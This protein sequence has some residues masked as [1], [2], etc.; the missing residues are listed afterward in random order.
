M[1]IRILPTQ[2]INQIAAGEVVER[3]A[4]AVKELV[5][6]SFDAGAR[7]VE[8][9]VEQGGLRLL[10]IRDD[11]CGIAR[12]ELSLALSRH[13]T[14]KI[15]GLDDLERVATMGFRGEAL[16]SISSVSRLTLTS[17][18]QGEDHAWRVTADGTETDFDI[19]PAAHPQGTS[20]EV[21]DLFYNTP[22][23]RK[24]LR[25]EKTEF[26]H[27]DNLVRRMALSRFGIGFALT[28]NQRQVLNLRP[29][30]SRADVEKRLSLVLGEDFLEQALPVEFG[31]AGL[32]LSGWVG[33]PT[34]SR[35]QT[36]M[37][38]FYVN[39][40][41]VRDKLV[42][43]AIRQAYQDVL[44][45]GR[46]P[47]YVLYLEL[48]PAQV[49][50]NAHPAKLEVRFR[51]SRMVHDFLFRG[52][53]RALAGTKAGASIDN[54]TPLDAFSPGQE[55]SAEGFAP[56]RLQA[57][58]SEPTAIPAPRPPLRMSPQPYAGARPAS[59]QESLPLNVADVMEGY[60]RLYAVPDASPPPQAVPQA[61]EETVPPLGFALAHLHGAFILAENHGGLIL[62]DAHAAHE[63]ITYEKLKTQC[64]SGS[65]ASQP[66]LLPIRLGV[67][68]T[69]ADLAEEAAEALAA[70]GVEFSR[71]GPETLL[72][73]AVPAL[74][75][76]SDGERLARDLLA[77]LQQHGRS[78]RVEEAM[79]SV[80]ATLACHGSV[81][82]NRRL[83]VPEM[84]RLLRE[85]EATE[86][87][88]QCNHGR[89]T[90]V[91]LSLKDLN[92][93]FLRGR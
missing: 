36:D 47:V 27:I 15:A 71:A 57:Y 33:L 73:R 48:D 13:A 10:R 17:R 54:P 24:F 66:L 90:W 79:N 37:Q 8:I 58:P 1:P 74:L 23:R 3:P 41:L 22:A 34:F 93:L 14:S 31:A 39:G 12:E 18:T 6:N 68:A 64:A 32:K 69:E 26:Q 35:S 20:V 87:S 40:R 25:T 7:C 78:F 61:A 63:R 92:G 46:Q 81:R 65:V 38:F 49:D 72:L 53:Q 28:H 50:V 43:A 42:S 9:D 83:S 11:G 86:R 85:M 55:N 84:N 88:G 76:D 62:V 70:L 89:P 16:P 44:Y 51:E 56:H 5:E 29:A 60:R 21:R 52:L 80:L 4:S 19:Q 67:T 2:L 77:D 59:R 75:A 82:A 91:E 30:Q 45:Q